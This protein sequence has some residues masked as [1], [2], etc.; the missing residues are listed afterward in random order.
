MNQSTTSANFR[1]ENRNRIVDDHLGGGDH[2]EDD[3]DPDVLL[4]ARVA[5]TVGACRALGLLLV[6]VGV[7]HP[8]S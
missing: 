6:H 7:G 2:A 5:P 1:A 4:R 8:R 3:G